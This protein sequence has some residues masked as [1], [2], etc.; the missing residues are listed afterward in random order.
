MKNLSL[1]ER[2]LFGAFF[3]LERPLHGPGISEA[4]SKRFPGFSGF[5]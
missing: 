3:V 2:P 5:C 4:K 1:G